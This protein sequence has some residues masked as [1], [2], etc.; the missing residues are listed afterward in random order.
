MGRD[1]HGFEQVLARGGEA[2]GLACRWRGRIAH[3]SCGRIMMLAA[4]AAFAGLVQASAVLANDSTASLDAG[5]LTLTFNPDISMESEDLYLS[6]DEV[7]VTYHFHNR[8]DHDIATLVAFPLPVINIGEEGNYDLEGRDPVNVMDFRVTADG[9]PVEPSVEIKAT[10]FGVDVTDVLKRYDIPLTMLAPG[11]GAGSALNTRLDDLSQDAR[12]ELERYGVIDWNTTFGAAEKPL[13]NTHWDTHITFYWFQT[14]PAGSTIEVTHRYKPVP[15]RFFF[16]KDDLSSPETR[17]LFCMDQ[18]F[19][20]VAQAALKQAPQDIL[21]GTELK[22][23]LT[24][25]GNWLGPIQ[26]FRL[27]VEKPSDKALVSLCAKGI[28]RAGSTTFTLAQD[29]YVPE[30]D[31]NILFVEPMPNL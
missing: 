5:G 25:A 24:T 10:R 14:F 22:Y 21:A 31:L 30:G 23:V 16:A 19:I 20:G 11:E 18:D 8:A 2:L 17:K 12:Q 15:R 1:R 3:G 28:K 26:K 6:R 9:K 27:T 13:A 7:R 29:D 4:L